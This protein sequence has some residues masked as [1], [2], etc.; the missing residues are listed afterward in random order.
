M[1]DEIAEQVCRLY[2]TTRLSAREISK[3][4]CVTMRY[5][6]YQLEKAG[7]VTLKVYDILG[8]EVATLVEAFQDAGKHKTRFNTA[9]LSSGIYL[10]RIESNGFTGLKKLVL[11][12]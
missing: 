1:K 11:L 2:K 7:R 9:N 3:Q 10:Y 6:Y 5:V 8:N 12:K 4:L